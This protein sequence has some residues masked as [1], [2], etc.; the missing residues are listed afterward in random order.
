[1]AVTR[2]ATPLD[3]FMADA[4]VWLDQAWYVWVGIG[5]AAALWIGI[6]VLVKWRKSVN[7]RTPHYRRHS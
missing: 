5:V 4:A 3:D 2:F 7:A 6:A 1:M